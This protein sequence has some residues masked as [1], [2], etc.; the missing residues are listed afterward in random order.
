MGEKYI[1]ETRILNQLKQEFRHLKTNI[2]YNYQDARDYYFEKS[3]DCIESGMKLVYT[4]I[5]DKIKERHYSDG[6]FTFMII[7][8]K[9]D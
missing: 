5:D 4:D 8:Y 7:L 6:Q 2:F 1:V 9:E 3:A